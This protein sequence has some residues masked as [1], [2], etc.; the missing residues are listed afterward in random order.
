M[1]DVSSLAIDGTKIFDVSTS[2]L[3]LTT[4]GTVEAYAVIG[5]TEANTVHTFSG[6]EFGFGGSSASA[7]TSNDN[8]SGQ[9]IE[10]ALASS[11]IYT[12]YIES[13]AKT[14]QFTGIA[15]GSNN[16]Y[17]V[18]LDESSEGK[19]AFVA[20]GV[21]PL[22][23]TSN[24]LI[25]GNLGM[26]VGTSTKRYRNMYAQVFDG[27]ATSAQYADLA[28][29][30]KADYNY[31]PGTVLMFGGI[32]E[33][34][35]SSGEMNSQVA[36]VVSTDPAYLMNTALQHAQAVELAMMGRVP[37]KVIGKISKGD[38]LITSRENGVATASK[39]PKLGTVIGKALENYDSDQ[40]GVIEIVVGKL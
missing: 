3:K 37:C 33:V 15:F 24:G 36:G 39:D 7:S 2:E 38:M 19:V 16:P 9:N 6:N 18:G 34:T 32:N 12:K 20:D 11:Y 40:V 17:I 14:V 26:D 21:V 28:E 13:D 25:P 10:P 23:A 27:V 35:I 22:I 31:E 29:R 4:P 8:G 1:L 5:S 30:F